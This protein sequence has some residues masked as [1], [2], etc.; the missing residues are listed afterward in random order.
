MNQPEM[1]LDMAAVERLRR[2]GGQEFLVELIDLFL[3]HGPERLEA[4]RSGMGGGDATLVFQASHSLKSTAGS[5]GG[6]VV[7]D[8]AQEIETLAAD[9]DLEQAAPIVERLVENFD[10]FRARLERERNLTS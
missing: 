1:T 6:R 8:L 5:L 2:L 10:E 9:G 7:Q 4:I 3:V